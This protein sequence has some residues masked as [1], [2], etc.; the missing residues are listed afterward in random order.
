MKTS[1]LV[2]DNV[3]FSYRLGD[4]KVPALRGISL[5]I[6][7]G[8]MV[9]IQGPSGSGKST[10]LYLLGCMLKPDSGRIEVLGQ[11]IRQLSEVELAYFR[12]RKLGFV[13]QQFHL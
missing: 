13:F 8:E 6:T 3:H 2:L 4:Q 5:Q 7:E 10:L 9:A 1:A 11:D 12:N